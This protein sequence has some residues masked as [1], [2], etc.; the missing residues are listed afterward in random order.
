MNPGPAAYPAGAEASS[1]SPGSAI[2]ASTTGM[3]STLH[4]LRGA[5]S[6]SSIDI[7][8]TRV[9]AL[10]GLLFA[11]Q[12][13]PAVNES[14]R[15]LYLGWAIAVPVVLFVLLFLVVVAAAL[16]RGVSLF[17]SAFAV[18]Y[19]IALAL[20]PVSVENL[21]AAHF[22]QPW[23]WY[24]ITLGMIFAALASPMRWAIVYSVFVTMVYVFIRTQPAGGGVKPELAVLDGVY[25]LL[26]GAFALMITTTLRVAADRV[27]AAQLTAMQQY[28]RAARNHAAE[29]ERA[30]VDALVHDTV[31]ATLIAAAKAETPAERARAV[32]L[33]QAAL[34]TLQDA[35]QAFDRNSDVGTRE[36]SG[37]LAAA[38][39]LLSPR[40]AIEDAQLGAGR[41]PGQ[42]ADAIFSAAVQALIN[43]L[44][45]AGRGR[46]SPGGRDGRDSPDSPDN[47]DNRVRRFVRMRTAPGDE[48]IVEVSDTGS[49]FDMSSVPPQR[50][51]LRVSIRE[52][53]EAVGGVVS[54]E[55][56]PGG[57][58]SVVISWKPGA[59]P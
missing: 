24:L 31:L 53:V 43:S 46:P 36:F 40:I 16:K 27:D 10:F 55:S 13:I 26:I 51:G 29:R 57:G 19:L 38:T 5:I 3:E 17:M 25:V 30:K 7:I 12:S 35:P 15:Y 4:R 42:V 34:K 41:I 50:L 18:A 9:T 8:M 59:R 49:G 2:P 39:R 11:V 23:L 56:T 48:L 1:A 33:S 22:S 52:R 58:T 54:V 14:S 21:G 45:H 37:R 20:W 32:S 44:Q 6:R 28:A 47:P